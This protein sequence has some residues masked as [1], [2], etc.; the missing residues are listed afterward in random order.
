[1]EPPAQRA[2]V[3]RSEIF[4]NLLVVGLALLPRFGEFLLTRLEDFLSSILKPGPCDCHRVFAEDSVVA[5][6]AIALVFQLSI[7]PRCEPHTIA[8]GT[9]DAS[10][11]LVFVSIEQPNRAIVEVGS[12]ACKRSGVCQLLNGV[13]SENVDKVRRH[14]VEAQISNNDGSRLTI[15]P[16]SEALRRIN[17]RNIRV[18]VCARTVPVSLSLGEVL[19]EQALR[20]LE[21]PLT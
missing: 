11:N 4:P 9:L 13:E 8:L 16:V 14:H 15:R 18:P 12:A 7:G 3:Q 6:W 20:F 5:D 17:L 19:S 2:F 10:A 1:D 21:P